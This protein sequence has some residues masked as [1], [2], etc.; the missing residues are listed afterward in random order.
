[1]FYLEQEAMKPRYEIHSVG[2]PDVV[3]TANRDRAA[4]ALFAA[5]EMVNAKKFETE[6]GKNVGATKY[7]GYSTRYS[8]Q[9]RSSIPQKLSQVYAHSSGDLVK[10]A[11]A[12]PAVLDSWGT[13]IHIER[14]TWDP[15]QFLVRS[16]G[17]DKKFNTGDDL[18]MNV[19][20]RGGTYLNRPDA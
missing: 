19:S 8:D 4:R 2:M 15:R 12:G 20:V 11:S 7:A 9:F 17:P 18:M 5:T 6:A 10:A 1:F 13:G 3:E 16:A 14:V